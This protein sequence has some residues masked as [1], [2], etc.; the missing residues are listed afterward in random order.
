MDWPISSTVDS[1]WFFMGGNP[2]VHISLTR[3]SVLESWNAH[4]VL[5]IYC[6]LFDRAQGSM[7]ASGFKQS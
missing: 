5:L 6:F 4:N 2:I 3:I 7:F 1:G